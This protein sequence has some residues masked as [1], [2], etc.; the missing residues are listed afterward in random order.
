MAPRPGELSQIL[1][2][3]EALQ[4]TVQSG[5]RTASLKLLR[6]LRAAQKWEKLE[7]NVLW[8]F[9]DRH[10]AV[11]LLAPRSSTAL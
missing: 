11:A 8:P 9:R 1:P 5:D 2:R 10:T 6:Y 7:L 3:A 4:P